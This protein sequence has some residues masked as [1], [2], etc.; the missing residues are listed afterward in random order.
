MR[1]ELGA[2]LAVA[3]VSYAADTRFRTPGRRP[4]IPRKRHNLQGKCLSAA[5]RPRS[6]ASVRL[7][8]AWREQFS[9]REYAVLVDLLARWLEA[10][11]LKAA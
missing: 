10:E 9:P 1:A 7:L 8:E 2:E 4:G 5:Y 6:S 3:M 11:R